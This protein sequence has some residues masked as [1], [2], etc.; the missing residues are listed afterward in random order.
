M[1][2]DNQ[3]KTIS[4]RLRKFLLLLLCVSAIVVLYTTNLW[5]EPILGVTR[6]H[7]TV[8][9]IAVILLYYLGDYYLDL[10]YIY[11]S[12]HGEKIILRYYSLRP[13][14]NLKNSIEIP[15]T[16]FVNYEIQSS[17]FNLKPY[18]ILYARTKGKTA[19]YPSVCLSALSSQERENIRASLSRY[20]SD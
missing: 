9:L 15:K 4:I 7:M 17:W 3:R 12:D 16:S 20:T 5:V 19:R 18:L 14:Q 11:F 6:V 13:M 10:N 2:I 1:Q 8:F